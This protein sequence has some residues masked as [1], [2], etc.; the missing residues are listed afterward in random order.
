MQKLSNGNLA[1]PI[2][3][4]RCISYGNQSF[5]LNCKSNDWFLYEMQHWAEMD[6]VLFQWFV[7]NNLLEAKFG[8]GP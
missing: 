3:A 2:L 7:S 4:Q 1:Y 5:D 6:K 8:D